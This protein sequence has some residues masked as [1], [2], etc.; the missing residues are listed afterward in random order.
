M[1]DFITC[2]CRSF[3]GK[4]LPEQMQIN[5]QPETA[6]LLKQQFSAVQEMTSVVDETLQLYGQL[7]FNSVFL[8]K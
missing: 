4:W 3:R 1:Y 6:Q 7:H 5:P 2:L 8:M